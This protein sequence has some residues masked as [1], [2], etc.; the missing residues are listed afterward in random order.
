M[1][2]GLILSFLFTI[3]GLQTNA[4][5]IAE[6]EIV[7]TW[8]VSKVQ[9]LSGNISNDEKQAMEML[10]D[11]FLKSKFVFKADHNFSFEF[12][13]DEMRIRNGHWKYNPTNSSIIIQD[14][15][16]KDKDNSFLMVLFIKKLDEKI[17]FQIDET[18]FSLE[19]ENESPNR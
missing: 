9:I 12:S 5:Q 19:M 6:N 15:K 1:K 13:I 4:Q 16:D 18:V 14:W 11:P 10:K 3:I 2:K 7:G 17:I 8:T